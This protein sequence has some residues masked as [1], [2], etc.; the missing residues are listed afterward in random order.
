M[1]VLGAH[2]GFTKEGRGLAP[3]ANQHLVLRNSKEVQDLVKIMI[4]L[5]MVADQR[6]V[7]LLVPK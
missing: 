4:K 3:E 7:N 2:R 1:G 6:T 5:F